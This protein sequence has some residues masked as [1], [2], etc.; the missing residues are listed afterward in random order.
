[1]RGA[2]SGTRLTGRSLPAL[3]VIQGLVEGLEVYLPEQRADLARLVP[4]GVEAGFDVGVDLGQALHGLVEGPDEL[5][6]W[7]VVQRVGELLQLADLLLQTLYIVLFFPAILHN[8][9]TI[10]HPGPVFGPPKTRARPDHDDLQRPDSGRRQASRPTTEKPRTAER[11]I[12]ERRTPLS[13]TGRRPRQHPP[14]RAE[15]SRAGR[16]AESGDA[17]DSCLLPK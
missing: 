6:V 12:P 3:V 10:H 8:F 2:R 5:L 4:C 15:R 7:Y 9:R 16:T 13:S 11:P 17:C 1:M 14:R